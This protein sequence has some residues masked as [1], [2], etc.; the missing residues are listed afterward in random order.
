MCWGDGALVFDLD[1]GYS[2]SKHHDSNIVVH[3]NRLFSW[4]LFL[5][6]I[7]TYN[8]QL[9]ERGGPRTTCNPGY[10]GQMLHPMPLV[11]FNSTAELFPMSIRHEFL[12]VA[13]Y[14]VSHW[15][16]GSIPT[17]WLD[18]LLDTCFFLCHKCTLH[19]LLFWFS[20]MLFTKYLC[21]IWY[22]SGVYC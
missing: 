18:L 9:T 1:R 3:N 5:F 21:S 16:S 10:V 6:T 7:C 20:S 22:I 15:V 13:H 14:N 12:M 11:H 17:T 2:T 8:K 19:T 4:C